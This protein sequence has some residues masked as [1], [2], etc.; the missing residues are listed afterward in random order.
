M[1]GMCTC[2]AL[3]CRA[4]SPNR[5]A[6]PR[7]SSTGCGEARKCFLGILLTL[8]IAADAERW[9]FPAH[10]PRE[11]ISV[12]GDLPCPGIWAPDQHTRARRQSSPFYPLPSVLR[13]TYPPNPPLG[14]LTFEVLVPPVGALHESAAQQT[15]DPADG[16]SQDVTN[17]CLHGQS[18]KKALE[19]IPTHALLSPRKPRGQWDPLWRACLA[20]GHRD[21]ET[22]MPPCERAGEMAPA[23]GV[24]GGGDIRYPPRPASCCAPHRPQVQDSSHFFKSLT[25]LAARRYLSKTQPNDIMFVTPLIFAAGSIFTLIS[26][27]PVPSLPSRRSATDVTSSPLDAR[28]SIVDYIVFGGDGDTS[29][30]WPSQDDWVSDFDTLY[31]FS[32]LPE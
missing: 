29:A 13:W 25:L 4:L 21:G 14:G 22:P 28:Q 31:V 7:R 26:G 15:L 2:L 17:S 20:R 5:R 9:P 6:E 19:A 32:L 18:L 30:G 3:Y 12:E 1:Y 11:G 10:R 16:R 27:A 8:V 23:K 24:K